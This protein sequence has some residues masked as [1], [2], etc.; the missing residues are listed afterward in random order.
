M[1]GEEEGGRERGREK[2]NLVIVGG[3]T[4]CTRVKEELAA[5]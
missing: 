1:G 5:S 3:N 2:A 4:M